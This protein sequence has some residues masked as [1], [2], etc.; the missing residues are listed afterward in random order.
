MSYQHRNL[1]K[2]HVTSS[3]LGGDAEEVAQSVRVLAAQA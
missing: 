2:D 3:G 1:E